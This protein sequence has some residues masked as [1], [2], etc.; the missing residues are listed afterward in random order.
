[1]LKSKLAYTI[2]E[3]VLVILLISVLA[4]VFFNL[5][6]GGVDSWLMIDNRKDI[7]QDGRL[8]IDRVR[9]A[10]RLADEVVDPSPVPLAPNTFNDITVRFDI[11]NDGKSQKVRYYRSGGNLLRMIDGFP[12]GGDIIAG[13]V[14]DFTLK[15][16]GGPKLIEINLQLTKG[17]QTVKLR[18]DA[19]AR[20]W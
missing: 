9:D 5:Y 13:G 20:N 14:S 2:V 18:T 7:L 15:G 11:D 6:I 16:K 3:L 4:G 17:E 10:I 8:A 19:Y 1:M 12:A